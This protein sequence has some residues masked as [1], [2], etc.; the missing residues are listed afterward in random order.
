SCDNPTFS[1]NG[2]NTLAQKD[3]FPQACDKQ[4]PTQC[5]TGTGGAANQNTA[6]NPSAAGHGAAG[7]GTA[8]GAGSTAAAGSAA[9]SAQQQAACDPDTGTCPA[10][11]GALDNTSGQQVNGVPLASA[12]SLGDG[13]QVTLMIVAALLLLGLGL[14]PP[15]ISQAFARRRA[16]RGGAR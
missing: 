1:T 15:L 10:N 4:G 9:T 8:G 13:L 7:S 3:P 16:R 5:V 2:T 11:G 12:A 14:A 6:V